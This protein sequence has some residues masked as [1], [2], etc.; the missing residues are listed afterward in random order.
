MP[1]RTGAG[2]R[3]CGN[4]PAALECGH[5][6]SPPGG[7]ALATVSASSR[8]RLL[9]LS[10]MLALLAASGCARLPPRGELPPQHALPVA[11]GR[12]AGPRIPSAVAAASGRIGVPAGLRWRGGVR[13]AR[14]VG[15]LRRAQPRRAV[16]HLARRPDRLDAGARAGARGR[17]RRARAPAA[18]RHGRPRPQLRA[19][20]PGR[21]SRHR[22]ARCSIRSPRG[23]ARPANWPKG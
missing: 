8:L 2:P 20:R 10:A 23:A 9:L 17:S 19:G 15:A 11:H 5:P 7:K 3:E 14:T 12:R 18:G 13:A 1:A 16:L 21:P 22:G 4:D 6:R